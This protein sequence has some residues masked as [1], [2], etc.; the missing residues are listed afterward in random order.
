MRKQGRYVESSRAELTRWLG[1]ES[2]REPVQ[3][4]TPGT[5]LSAELKRGLSFLP[6]QHRSRETSKKTA[7]NVRANRKAALGQ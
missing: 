1:K 6:K 5:D 4:A 3:I 7:I 2:A